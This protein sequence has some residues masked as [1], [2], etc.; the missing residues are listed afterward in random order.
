MPRL[1]LLV[2]F[3]LAVVAAVAAEGTTTPEPLYN[4]RGS[5]QLDKE[6]VAAILTNEEDHGS[7]EERGFEQELEPMFASLPKSEPGRIGDRAARYALHRFFVRRHGWYIRG[8]EP[9]NATYRPERRADGSLPPGWR[10]EWL[11]NFLADKLEAHD[12]NHGVTLRELA[13]LAAAL[14]DIVLKE[15]RRRM[16]KVYTVHGEPTAHPLNRVVA[17]DLLDTYYITFLLANNFTARSRTHLRRKKQNF[18]K[19][20]RGYAAARAWLVENILSEMSSA[21]EVDFTTNV[22]LAHTIGT[23]YHT[24][25]Q[26]ECT[27]LRAQLKTMESKKPGR[28]HL[29]VF[30]NATRYTHWKFVE[31]PEY[32][33]RL[34][35][36]DDTDP[37][38]PSLIT[39]N[40]VTARP[41]CLDVS[42]VYTLCCT[43]PCESLMRHLEQE[44]GQATASVEKVAALVANL[45]STDVAAPRELPPALLARLQEIAAYH[46]GEV[47]LHGRLFAQWMHHAYPRECPFPQLEGSI[48][49]QT[50]EEWTAQMGASAH[51]SEAERHEAVERD[52][53][54]VTEDGRV[55]CGEEDTELPWDTAEEL[56]TSARAAAATTGSEGEQPQVVDEATHQPLFFVALALLGLSAALLVASYRGGR[57]AA[58]GHGGRNSIMFAAVV[59][60]VLLLLNCFQLVD[61]GVFLFALAFSSFVYAVR[62]VGAV[63]TT[64]RKH[65][66]KSEAF[67]L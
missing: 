58:G 11:L 32:L 25:N 24:L 34:G 43:S 5:G 40:Y 21:E 30:Y 44:I 65:K 45:A 61:E 16:E 15:T 42:S 31:K 18:H 56:L 19:K 50:V 59:V 28:V 41:N 39:A 63:T 53:C 55:D 9:G 8:L 10:D 13:A 47:P 33:K 49:P 54:T 6:E 7:P 26:E 2:L 29:S 35:A 51:T 22:H 12:G 60:L 27:Q 66:V 46:G 62:V 20:Y 37:A 14:E 17:E 52:H 64:T 48:H 3:V 1:F 57:A 67:A 23:K 4:F 38:Q 36:L